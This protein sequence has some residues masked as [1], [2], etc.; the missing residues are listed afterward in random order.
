MT[1]AT[2]RLAARQIIHDL[3][4]RIP[5]EIPGARAWRRNVGGAMTA[6]GFVRFGIPGE[7]DITGIAPNGK[8][9]EIEVKAAGDRLRPEQERFLAM[10]NEAGGIGIVARDVDGAIREIQRRISQTTNRCENV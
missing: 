5:S 6:T 9:I 10:V 7:A 1:S 3:L 2:P 8:R 4:I